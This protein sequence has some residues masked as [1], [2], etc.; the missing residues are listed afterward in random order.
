MVKVELLTSKKVCFIYYNEITLRM[1]KNTFYFI[2]KGVYVLRIF[3]YLS[4]LFNYV[5]KAA[6][7]ER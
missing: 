5:E 3:K 2:L 7:L 4:W 6:W 1:M